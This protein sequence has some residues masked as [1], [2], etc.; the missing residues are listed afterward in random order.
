MKKVFVIICILSIIFTV[1]GC[2]TKSQTEEY[3]AMPASPE[4]ENDIENNNSE[5]KQD[6]VVENINTES[7]QDDVSEVPEKDEKTQEKN[8][9]TEFV[10]VHIDKGV[11]RIETVEAMVKQYYSADIF[12]GKV[13][14]IEEITVDSE[15]HRKHQK[16]ERC[17]AYFSLNDDISSELFLIHSKI[18]MYTVEVEKTVNSVFI[19]PNT[20]IK[21][22]HA[23]N[24]NG[25]PYTVGQR[26]LMYG[27]LYEYEQ[28]T[29]L[30]LWKIF[31]AKVDDEQKLTGLF[32]NA[33]ILDEIGTVENFISNQTLKQL[34]EKS[35][36]IPEEY[37]LSYGAQK[38]TLVSD[39]KNK[40]IVNNIL[41]DGKKA[42]IADSDFKM[43]L[44]R[45]DEFK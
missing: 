45:K 8:S 28:E 2:K 37:L 38:N 10:E 44:V 42:I 22:I 20:T 33:K 19:Q 6:E 31:A 30:R 35:I 12:I 7:E 15:L 41:S 29:V 34:Y 17:S 3:V 23:V 13:V 27:T 16:H 4:Q 18:Y 36:I 25:E 5:S 11:N 21:M 26:Y 39:E 32:V 43:N 9:Q 24:E 1:C 40:D 14:G